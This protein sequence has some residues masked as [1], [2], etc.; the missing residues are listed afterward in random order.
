MTICDV[1][2]STL[3]AGLHKK[4]KKLDAEQDADEAK[5]G[6]KLT[7]SRLEISAHVLRSIADVLNDI[8]LGN[9]K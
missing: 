4:A 6:S 2:L 1:P 7:V 8:Y 3:I 5:Y 9:V